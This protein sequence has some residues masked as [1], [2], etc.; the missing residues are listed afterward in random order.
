MQVTR[1]DSP[2]A[3]TLPIWP[4]LGWCAVWLALSFGPVLARMAR[5]W[6]ID[7]DM[8]HGFFVPV[9]AGYIAWQSRELLE[10]TPIK[11]NWWGLALMALASCQLMAATLGVELFLARTAFVLSV[12]GSVL[13]VG[14]WQWAKILGLPLF[15]LLF[16]VPLPAIIYNQI[17]FP[18]QLLA[19]QVAET[20]LGWCGL[21]VLRDGN[22][23][24]LPN[25]RLNVV[26]ACSG[27][28]SLL[29]L[30]FLSLVYGYFFDSRKWMKWVLLPLTVPIAIAANAGRVTIS[31]LLGLV[32]AK[33]LE[34]TFHT[35][36]GWVLF[37]VALLL[38]VFT[39]KLICLMVRG[40]KSDGPEVPA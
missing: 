28:R 34:G 26:E 7:E 20:A 31:G 29:S 22:I 15:L 3:E 16:M 24:E 21:P 17:T 40:R 32:S 35:A 38:L 39:H 9:V 10:K 2:R 25:Q 14:G 8:G 19:S 4:T 37:L 6:Y 13:L 11:T 1:S 23:L 27:I 18:L 30:T 36:E 33:L 12:V 5:D